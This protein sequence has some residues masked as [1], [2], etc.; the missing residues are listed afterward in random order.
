MIRLKYYLQTFFGRAYS[1]TIFAVA[2]NSSK[3]SPINVYYFNTYRFWESVDLNLISVYLCSQLIQRFIILKYNSSTNSKLSHV[4]LIMQHCILKKKYLLISVC[5]S[6]FLKEKVIMTKIYF[7][8]TY[9][10]VQLFLNSCFN[11]FL[12]LGLELQNLDSLQKELW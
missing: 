1:N 7:N 11:N 4:M 9:M 10:E 8:F 12:N 6:I 3:P 2:T 5:C